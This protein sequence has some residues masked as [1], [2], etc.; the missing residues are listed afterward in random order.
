MSK[1]SMPSSKARCARIWCT[2]SREAD[3]PAR[4]CC[5]MSPPTSLPA[6][7]QLVP[8]STAR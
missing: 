6:R 8:F 5:S 3:P 1:S 4:M 7:K 2:L